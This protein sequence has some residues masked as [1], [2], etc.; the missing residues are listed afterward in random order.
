MNVLEQ[1]ILGILEEQAVPYEVVEH[2]PVYTNPQM[3]EKLGTDEGKTVKNLMLETND[4]RIILV[5]L[6]G[7][8]RFDAKQLAAKANAKKVSFARPE[9]VLE[10]AGC[11]VGCVPPFGHLKP[12]QVYMDSAL[13]RKTFVY[14]NP[15]V[16]T[17]SVKIDPVHLK[18]LCQ[19]IM[20]Y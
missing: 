14:F 8:K 1:K 3:A 6:P 18:R 11:E 2:D 7:D 16:H 9:V 19:P 10:T 4:G 13:L 17:K 15:G 12:V 20:M 5:V